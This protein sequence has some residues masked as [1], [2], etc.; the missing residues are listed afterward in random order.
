MKERV[1]DKVTNPKI[2]KSKAATVVI[3]LAKVSRSSEVGHG[4]GARHGGREK[5]NQGPPMMLAGLIST[6]SKAKKSERTLAETRLEME[7]ISQCGSGGF[8]D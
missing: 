8:E 2:V 7:V 1:N 3:L 6:A 4:D 5:E